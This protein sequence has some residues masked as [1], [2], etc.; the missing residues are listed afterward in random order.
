MKGEKRL[1]YMELN[2]NLM[3]SKISKWL[4]ADFRSLFRFISVAGDL[5][6][7]AFIVSPQGGI[8][9]ALPYLGPQ[10]SDGGVYS[11]STEG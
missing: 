4:G 10:R 8:N 1:A 11:R 5:I 9:R 7:G 6:D 3:G 2:R